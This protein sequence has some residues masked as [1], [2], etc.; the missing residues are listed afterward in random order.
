M[1]YGALQ[2]TNSKKTAAFHQPNLRK[3]DAAEKGFKGCPGYVT[4][5]K[6]KAPYS[7]AETESIMHQ[8]I[9]SEYLQAICFFL[10]LVPPKLQSVRQSALPAVG[11]FAPEHNAVLTADG[12]TLYVEETAVARESMDLYFSI[13]Y[14]LRMF[15]QRTNAAPLPDPID[16]NAFAAY[17]MKSRFH[18]DPVFD[19]LS[20]QE[21]AAVAKREEELRLHFQLPVL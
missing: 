17:Q 2:L 10:K 16:A 7:G 12:Q 14:L 8:K 19:T 5:K 1:A 4:M 6:R 11:F 18:V 20:P 21:Q 3:T 9:F 15:W 13:A